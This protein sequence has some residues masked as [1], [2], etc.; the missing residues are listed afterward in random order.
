[1]K[2]FSILLLA[3]GALASPRMAALNARDLIDITG[4]MTAIGAAIDKTAAALNGWDGQAATV[5]SVLTSQGEILEQMKQAAAKIS[6]GKSLGLMDATSVIGPSNTLSAQVEAVMTAMVGKKAAFEKLGVL[7]AVVSTL[8]EQKQGADALAKAILE[9]MP[10]IAKPIAEPMAK[11]FGDKLD[12]ALL[13]LGPSTG[14][15]A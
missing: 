13:Q 15:P 2:C 6:A 10:A 14:A 1:M 5:E 7:S 11:Q 9:K 3:A 12:A 4:G 8:N